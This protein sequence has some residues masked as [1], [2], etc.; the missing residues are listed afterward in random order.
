MTT[1]AGIRPA[2]EDD[3][4]AIVALFARVY[5]NSRFP[6]ARVQ[7]HLR[8]V[9]FQHPWQSEQ[10]TSLAYVD[11][12]GRL[13]G[14]LGV[15]PRPMLAGRRPIMMAVSHHFM[16]DREHRATLA[17]LQLL[18]AF[19]A[20]HQDLAICESA[21]E[22]RKLWHAVG[23]STGLL[24]S[25]S[26]T[27]PLQPVQHLASGLHHFGIPGPMVTGLLPVC[28]MLDRLATTLRSSPY[29]LSA[30]AVVSESL[31][32]QMLVDWIAKF[33]DACFL[34]PHYDLQSLTW[35]LEIL[36]EKQGLGSLQVRLVRQGQADPL[37]YYLYLAKRG[38]IG[39]VLQVAGRA[40][41]MGIVFDAM[42]ADACRRGVVALT[43]RLDPRHLSEMYGPFSVK[44]TGNWFL[45]HAREP[46]LE[47]AVHK[48]EAFL[49][50]LESEWWL[51]L[52]E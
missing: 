15:L 32:A 46:E 19:L 51:P 9:L 38:G 39:Q 43:G 4:P 14:F 31:T 45:V 7:A 8:K 26:W 36:A 40:D 22:V 25:P 1:S 35:L 33:S 34:R 3:L 30:G 23:G 29:R 10:L 17:A 18:Q 5:P 50:R 28:R 11:G 16:V 49:T 48:G 13:V 6:L 20:G 27:R 42:A 52:H 24:L 21:A 2:R 12:S 44:H 37:G 41:A 47:R